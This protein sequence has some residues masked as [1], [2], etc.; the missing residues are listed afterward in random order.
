LE[1][2]QLPKLKSFR[3]QRCSKYDEGLWPHPVQ[4]TEIRLS[5]PR[6]VL[7]RSHPGAVQRT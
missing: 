7:E 5:P 2:S 3:V 4:A 6:Q 1:S